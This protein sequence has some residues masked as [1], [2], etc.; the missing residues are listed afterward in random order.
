MAAVMI[1]LM[2]QSTVV[3]FGVVGTP[4]LISVTGGLENPLMVARLAEVNQTFN[5]CR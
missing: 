2:V 5:N 1:G 3:T 4:V